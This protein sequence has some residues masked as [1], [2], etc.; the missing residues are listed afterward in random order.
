MRQV[1][2]VPGLGLGGIELFVLKNRLC[3]L[4]F[5]AHIFYYW[6]WHHSIE[7][8]AESL[9]SF[10]KDISP[11]G[12]DFVAHSLGGLIVERFSHLHPAQPPFRLVTLGTPHV[13]SEAAN[14]FMSLP[15]GTWL[16]GRALRTALEQV[17]TNI[18]A[19][20]E[21]GTVA[22]S[23]NTGMGWLLGIRKPNDSLICVDEA[24]HP[25]ATDKITLKVSHAAML[26]SRQVVLGVCS[27]LKH[28]AFGQ[29]RQ[30]VSQQN[31]HSEKGP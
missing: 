9:A 16:L 12:V 13:G 26:V 21:L 2:L 31:T 18:S 11:G 6:A 7:E 10:V 5:S 1:V 27:F 30:G 19:A 29:Q 22:G 25:D 14:R 8:N 3:R 17:P 15:G 28:G 24:H 4:G 20:I 23:L